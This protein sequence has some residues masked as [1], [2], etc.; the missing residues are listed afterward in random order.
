[1]ADI[2]FDDITDDGNI[3]Y[4][5]GKNKGLAARVK[6]NLDNLD[7]SDE[8]VNVTIP[9]QVGCNESFLGGLFS[10][11]ISLLGSRSSFLHK[12]K[13]IKISDEVSERLSDV[14]TATLSKGTALS[15]L[16]K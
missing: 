11:S 8:S 9:E 6:F 7:T 16:K 15:G 10:N 4:L 12:Y 3:T 14:I 5:S 13:F 1:M 2:N